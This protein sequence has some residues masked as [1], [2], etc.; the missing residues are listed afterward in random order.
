M[1]KLNKRK[2][3]A[4]DSRL[5]E[6]IRDYYLVAPSNKPYSLDHPD[7]LDNS[8]GQAP[9]IDNML[10]YKENGFYVESGAYDGEILSNTLLFE[11]MR[12][13][14]GVLVEPNPDVFKK[15]MK[16]NRNAYAINACLSTE[17]YPTKKVL[18]G[19]SLQAKVLSQ[20]SSKK[21]K[22]KKQQKL[23][24][25]FPLYSILLAL[26]QTSIDYFSLDVEGDEK[27]VLGTIPWQKV[28]IDMLSVE[29]DKWQ[30]GVRQL[31][32]FMFTKGYDCL[33]ALSGYLVTDVILKKKTPRVRTRTAVAN[34]IP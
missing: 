23:V 6:L 28:K 29:Y 21:R 16:K 24:Q 27:G 11:R 30:G 34:E 2:V 13:W 25:C 32:K 33:V 15:L 7:S 20:K 5:I 12:N 22:Q 8:R 1:T 18:T 19:T 3:G 26:N 31:C 10:K 9:I 14:N 17:P 4:D